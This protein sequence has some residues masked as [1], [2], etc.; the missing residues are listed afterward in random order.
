M[1]VGVFTLLFLIGAV[2][3]NSVALKKDHSV[4]ERYLRLSDFFEGVSEDK[5]QELILSPSFGETK[6]YPHAWVRRL[7]KNFSL[8][9]APENHKGISLYREGAEISHKAIAESIRQY[10][11]SEE[12]DEDSQINI[13]YP[14]VAIVTSPENVNFLITEF[15]KTGGSNFAAKLHL[16]GNDQHKIVRGTIEKMQEMPVLKNAIQVGGIIRPSDID[17]VSF[18]LRK[19]SAQ[20]IQS[21]DL[22]AGKTVRSYSLKPGE[23]IRAADVTDPI[24][25]KKGTSVQIKIESD[26]FEVTT[27]GKALASGVIGETIQVANV[28][29]KKVLDCVIKDSSTVLIEGY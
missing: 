14:S 20:H 3:A 7:A 5:D 26:G 16:L 13:T 15:K 12:L 10:A 2:N 19:I 22:I 4:T 1:R 17:V 6:H 8:S 23:L 21:P 11:L 29:S 9:W 24:A 28:S 27:K 18:P 25:V